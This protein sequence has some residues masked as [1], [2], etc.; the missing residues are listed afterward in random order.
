MNWRGM[1]YGAMIDRFMALEA[2][3][4]ELKDELTCRCDEAFTSRGRHEPN[5]LCYLAD[6]IDE[7]APDLQVWTS[8]TL[9]Y[10]DPKTTKVVELAYDV[11]GAGDLTVVSFTTKKDLTTFRYDGDT[12]ADAALFLE[13]VLSNVS[14]EL[15]YSFKRRPISD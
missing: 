10:K 1:G 12:E 5:A 2:L 3:L 9:E 8:V 7:V 15:E 13:T 4:S 6:A 14:D 11:V